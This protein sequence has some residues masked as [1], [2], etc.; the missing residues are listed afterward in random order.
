MW[1][2]SA[3]IRLY[4]TFCATNLLW[5][6]GFPIPGFLFSECALRPVVVKGSCVSLGTLSLAPLF[7]PWDNLPKP[8]GLKTFGWRFCTSHFREFSKIAKGM[9]TS[10]Q[11]SIKCSKSNSFR[12]DILAPLTTFP[13]PQRDAAAATKI[14]LKLSLGSKERILSWREKGAGKG[15]GGVDLWVRR[16]PPR[17]AV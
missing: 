13:A 10:H 17:I 1:P 11:D 16:R 5:D 14:Y 8:L 6:K 12:E 7:L 2:E 15:P 3:T 9:L 4:G